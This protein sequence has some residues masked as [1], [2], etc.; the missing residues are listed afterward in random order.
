MFGADKERRTNRQAVPR[1]GE[2]R[3][4]GEKSALMA[5][6]LPKEHAKP[7]AII[8]PKDDTSLTNNPAIAAVKD[9]VFNALLDVINLGELSA[10]D[11]TKA[12]REIGSII[13]EIVSLQNIRLSTAEQA[14]LA[15]DI[16]HDLLGF[17]PLEPL[18]E[19]QDIGDIMV[20]GAGRVFIDTGGLI[21]ETNI[22]F[23]D[24]AHLTTI[25][26]RMAAQTGRHV[27]AA[28]PICDARLADGSRINI[29]LPPLATKG[30]TLTI[31]KFQKDR[32]VLR[33]LVNFGTISP[34]GA[35]LLAIIAA[36]RC[37]VLISGGTGS[38]KTTLLNCMT[39]F[40]GARE[41]IV[42]CEDTAELQLQ[43][44]HVVTL[45]TRPP[46]NEGRG[47]V[48]MRDLVRNCLRMRPERIIVGEVR[49]AE[50]LDL[51]QAMN[52]GHD[53]SMGTVHANTPRD[54]LARLETLV[55]MGGITLPGAV[56]RNMICGSIDIVVQTLRLRDGSRKIT[57]ITEVLHKDGD[58]IITQD[59]MT[60]KQ[61]GETAL[62]KIVGDHVSSGIGRPRFWERAESYGLADRLSAALIEAG[63][64]AFGEPEE[65]SVPKEG[66]AAR[67]TTARAA[68][69]RDQLANQG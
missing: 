7:I 28:S 3:H 18:L 11:K 67:Q 64:P 22:R 43:Q 29:I 47:E 9:S 15:E 66:R 35:K 41:R 38:G 21:Q 42:T 31:R 54:A 68:T 60:F 59:L 6:M 30:P 39:A 48:S 46:N 2:A 55:A 10:F 52:T 65:I 20:N 57:H 58:T 63:A 61:T 26:Q 1:F 23:R 17:G 4:A 16:C 50:A 27:D 40:M 25:C 36:C 62:G 56:V 5:E 19:R 53:G 12:K 32:L 33:D 37:N 13:S 8:D 45:E 69:I 44:R 24:E 49:G 51:L 14:L 34:A